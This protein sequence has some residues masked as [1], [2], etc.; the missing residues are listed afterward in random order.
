MYN[1]PVFSVEV[2][3]CAGVNAVEQS[4]RQNSMRSIITNAI[5]RRRILAAPL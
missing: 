3:T 5:K 1:V 2:E 4:I